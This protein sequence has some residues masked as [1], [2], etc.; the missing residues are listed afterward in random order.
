MVNWQQ[1]MMLACENKYKIGVVGAVYFLA[2]A[3]SVLSLYDLQKRYGRLQIMGYTQ[4]ASLICQAF[5]LTMSENLDTLIILMA[6]MGCTFVGKVAALM[7]L[8]EV[9]PSSGRLAVIA[10]TVGT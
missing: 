5:L 4:G 1:D 9:T 6:F 7:Y 2:A 3:I 10:T 8:L